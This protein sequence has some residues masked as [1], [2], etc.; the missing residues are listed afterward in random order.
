MVKDRAFQ[1]AAETWEREVES[2]SGFN[3]NCDSV[4][5]FP[6][7]TEL[8]FIDEWEHLRILSDAVKEIFTYNYKIKEGVLFLNSGKDYDLANRD[9]TLY[10]A[11]DRDSSGN[12]IND[13][14]FR[15]IDT[16]QLDRLPWADDGRLILRGCQS[17]LAGFDHVSIAEAFAYTQHVVTSGES[18]FAYFSESID[19]YVEISTSS[20][21][22][23]LKAYERR[24]NNVWGD[25]ES[26]EPEI[27]DPQYPPSDSRLE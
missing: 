13:G 22:V 5:L 26:M 19:R 16:K 4:F 24:L 20:K 25:G 10:L 18:G 1:R 9:S 23:Y 15:W 11:P 7:K 2:R 12:E 3:S 21:D 14:S 8:E 6:V 17:G 27:F